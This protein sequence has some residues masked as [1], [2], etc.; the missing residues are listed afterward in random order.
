M[1]LDDFL[2]AFAFNEVHSITIRASP[3]RVFHSIKDLTPVEIPLLRLLFAIRSLPARLAGK[4]RRSVEHSRPL[5]Q[6]LLGNGFI[7]LAESPNQELVLGTIGQFW[8]LTGNVSARIAEPSEF[9]TFSHPDYAKAAMNFSLEEIPG[10][11]II[12]V[13]TETRICV[14]DPATRKKFARYWRIIY[15]AS[16]LIRRMWLRAIKRRA[17]QEL[18]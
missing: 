6:Q 18:R 3:D 7:L 1:L 9:L 4:T 13:R 17:E 15:P 8:K 16:A 2:P 10:G 11:Q 12:T 5:L 14:P